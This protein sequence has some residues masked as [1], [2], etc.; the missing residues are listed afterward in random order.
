[1][2]SARACL[3]LSPKKYN[4]FSLSIT[5]G[6]CD[7]SILIRL[8]PQLWFWLPRNLAQVIQHA[9]GHDS[10]Q[11][12]INPDIQILQ[13]SPPLFRQPNDLP[14][15]SIP[16]NSFIQT[17]TP[18]CV[19]AFIDPFHYSYNLWR[20]PAPPISIVALLEISLTRTPIK[21]TTCSSLSDR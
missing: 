6:C 21:P 4:D 5:L 12:V 16:S 8:L 10:L 13:D 1:M 7:P 15:I 3:K 20:I 18:L 9:A 17:S 2:S 14:F 19:L 11:S